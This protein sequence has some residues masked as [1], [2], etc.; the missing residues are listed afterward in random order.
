MNPTN[1]AR[2]TETDAFR[3]DLRASNESPRPIAQPPR[4]SDTRIGGRR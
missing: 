2:E 3:A 1:H 4:S